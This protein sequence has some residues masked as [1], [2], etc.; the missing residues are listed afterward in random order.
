MNTGRGQLFSGTPAT[1]FH[2]AI[3]AFED[4]TDRARQR[5]NARHNPAARKFVKCFTI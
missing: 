5:V 4:V 3:Q 2:P 1:P